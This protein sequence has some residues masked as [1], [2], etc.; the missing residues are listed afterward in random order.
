[1]RHATLR[2]AE[3]IAHETDGLSPVGQ[4][5]DEVSAELAAADEEYS[6]LEEEYREIHEI[7][8]QVVH[9]R[10]LNHLTQRQLAGLVGTSYSQIA[11]LE[12]GLHKPSVD[13]LQRIARALGKRLRITFEPPAAAV[14]PDA[15][16]TQAQTVEHPV[17]SPM[18][19]AGTI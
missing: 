7:A 17:D 9:F 2:T 13:T 4:T 10:T 6:R 15:C 5:A 19:E 14:R 3:G 12:S 18:T 16:A 11:R 8:R 1:M